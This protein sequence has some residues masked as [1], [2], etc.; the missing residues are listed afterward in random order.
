MVVIILGPLT[1]LMSTKEEEE[2][3]ELL[4]FSPSITYQV[5]SFCWNNDFSPLFHFWVSGKKQKCFLFIRKP[6]AYFTNTRLL[7]LFFLAKP[8]CLRNVIFNLL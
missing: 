2:R 5:F 1:I 4:F 6:L 8:S 7:V 3:P